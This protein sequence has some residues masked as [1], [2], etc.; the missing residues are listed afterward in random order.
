[1]LLVALGLQAG[2][3]VHVPLMLTRG[4]TRVGLLGRFSLSVVALD[5]LRGGAPG[6]LLVFGLV[7]GLAELIDADLRLIA[8]RAERALRVR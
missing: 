5:R 7:A 4:V 2:V 8:R 3:Q 1:M 6:L